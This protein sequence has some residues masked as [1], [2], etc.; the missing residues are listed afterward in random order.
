[1]SSNIQTVLVTGASGFLG[2]TIVDELLAD[3]YKVRGYVPLF[4]L[5][6]FQVFMRAYVGNRTARSAKAPRVKAAYASF[7]DRFDVALVDDLATSDLSGAFEGVDALIHVGSPLA[8]KAT[9]EVLIKVNSILPPFLSIC[10]TDTTGIQSAVDGT[11]RVLDAALKAGVTKVVATASIISLAS[12]ARMHTPVTIG[13][14]GQSPLSPHPDPPPHILTNHASHVPDWSDDT[15]ER[16]TAAGPL[17]IY[18][19]SKTLAEQALWKFAAAHPELDVATVHPGFLYGKP[20]HG[21]VLDT[22]ADGTVPSSSGG[23]YSLDHGDLLHM[24]I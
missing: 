19:I 3:G 21:Q 23:S 22:P 13:A 16:A 20:G 24:C 17:A 4:Y 15:L 10:D 18:G 8:G 14:S 2:S 1:M 6:S 9:P 12:P 7:G 11:L 5:S